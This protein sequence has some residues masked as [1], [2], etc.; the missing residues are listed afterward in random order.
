MRNRK[1]AEANADVEARIAQIEQMTLE[2]IA[3]FQG[4]MLTDIG[5]GRIAPREAR[6]IDR[7]LRKR[8]KAIEQELQQDG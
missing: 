4:R 2:Q 1:A 5:T 6:A 7:A 8:L 3:T